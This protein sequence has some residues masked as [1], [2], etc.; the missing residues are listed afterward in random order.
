MTQVAMSE[1]IIYQYITLI[2]GDEIRILELL[3]GT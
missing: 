2:L 1:T 3:P